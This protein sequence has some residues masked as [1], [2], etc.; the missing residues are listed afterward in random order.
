LLLA[1]STSPSRALQSTFFFTKSHLTTFGLLFISSN[2]SVISLL[3]S[4]EVESFQVMI[5]GV[6]FGTSRFGIFLQ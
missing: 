4:F 1:V 3:V 6:C 2:E 5:L